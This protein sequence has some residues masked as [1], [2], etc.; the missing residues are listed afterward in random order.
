MSSISS[1]IGD[2]VTDSFALECLLVFSR[3]W[4]KEQFFW[5]VHN[6]IPISSLQA[7]SHFLLA[8]LS[9]SM[10]LETGIFI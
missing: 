3:I 10:I 4:I 7:R 1:K 9:I 6:A 8:D 5:R 2:L